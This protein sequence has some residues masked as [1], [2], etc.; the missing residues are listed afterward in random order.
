MDMSRLVVVLCAL[1]L[2]MTPYVTRSYPSLPDRRGHS[3]AC[4]H[5]INAVLGDLSYYAKY[6]TS[7]RSDTD[8]DLRVRTHLEFV[9]ALLSQRD[10]TALPADVREARRQNLARLREYI[11]AGRFPRNHLYRDENRPCFIDRDGRICAVGYLVECSA[12]REMAERINETFQSEFLWRMRLSQLDRW[13]AR[14]GLSLLELCMIQP[15]YAPE[16]NVQVTPSSD[17]APATVSITGNVI[18]RCGCPTKVVVFNFGDGS[19]WTSGDVNLV[20]VPVNANHTY[21][22]AGAYTITGT[23]VGGGACDGL[24]GSETWQIT[25]L[26]PLATRPS[27]WGRIKALYALRE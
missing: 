10:L 18:D 24:T 14:S 9:H 15:C 20:S 17:R 26:P 22:L 16:F 21:H 7:P 8:A 23:A 6:G 5:T 19:V 2:A 3:V 12:G 4:R 27:T 25:L 13:V 1:M 11:D